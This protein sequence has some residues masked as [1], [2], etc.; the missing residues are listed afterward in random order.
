MTKN[1]Y[2][3]YIG[4]DVSK[5]KLD[6]VMSHPDNAFLQFANTPEGLAN[7]VKKL[8]QTEETLLV[9]EASGGYEKYSATYL[10]QKGFAVA[11]VNAKRVRDFAKA[12]GKLAKTDRIDAKII[13]E[14]GRAFDPTPQALPSQE[15]DL[16]LQSLNRRTQLVKM[17]ALEKQHLETASDPYKKPIKKHIGSLEKQLLSLEA[18]LEKQFNQDPILQKKLK[19]LDAIKGVGKVTAMNVLIHL[20]ELGKLSHKEISA[21]AG[22]AP[23]NQDSGQMKGKRTIWGGR[24]QVRVAL[25]MAIL[26]AI[27]F[28]PI[29]NRFYKQLI[30]RGKIKKVAMVACMRK[31]ITIMNAMIKNDTE[32][33][34]AK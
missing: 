18:E 3:F 34:P 32:W 5:A 9:M 8:P 16:R 21:L 19:Q 6:V 4:V 20:P 33:N 15:D 13:M 28:N 31:L 7:F 25:Y 10:R 14:F 17:I 24:A 26:S 29:I 2:K 27:K 12:S 22:L 23:F 1:L 30:A 11:V